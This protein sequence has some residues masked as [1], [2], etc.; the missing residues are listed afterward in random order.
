MELRAACC[1][2]HCPEHGSGASCARPAFTRLYREIAAGDAPVVVRLGRLARSVSHLLEDLTARTA[3]LSVAAES[4]RH[5]DTPECAG[6]EVSAKGKTS[7]RR[8]S[9][10]RPHP[11]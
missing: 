4:D 11:R 8:S 5:R 3:H 6:S 7:L 2:T 10:N 1:E 9:S